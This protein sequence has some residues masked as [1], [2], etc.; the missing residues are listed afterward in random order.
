M[1][2]PLIVLLRVI[3]MVGI[4]LAVVFFS[5]RAYFLHQSQKAIESAVVVADGPV[6]GD[7]SSPFSI[8]EF[9]D[10][11]CSHC[12][13][14][15]RL[16]DSAVTGDAQ[17]KIILRPVVLGDEDSFKIASFVLAVE[18]QKQGAAAALHRQIM[19]LDSIPDYQAVVDVAKLQGIDISRA[20]DDAKLPAVQSALKQNTDWVSDIGFYGVPAL[21]IGD[22]GY[23]PHDGMPSVNGLKLMIL[24]A[25]S[26]LKIK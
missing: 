13:P 10:Y 9:F 18:K 25:K 14:M 15:S 19:Q 24:D 7:P 11:R 4:L 12:A 1:K 5:G 21:I 2:R 3:F 6:I 17:T 16:V 26:R 8:V 23:I 22:K 20:E